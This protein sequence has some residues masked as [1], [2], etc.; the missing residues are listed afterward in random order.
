MEERRGGARVSRKWRG[1][2]RRWWVASMA[3]GDVVMADTVNN[4][5]RRELGPRRQRLGRRST[6]APTRADGA[7]GQ[8]GAGSTVGAAY[9]AAQG[10]KP[11]MI[12]GTGGLG[13]R[14]G[15]LVEYGEWW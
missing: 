7:G 3:A 8:W 15:V 1:H 2:G 11:D 6:G 4:P 14:T 9:G 13:Y 5:Q 12:P 10:K